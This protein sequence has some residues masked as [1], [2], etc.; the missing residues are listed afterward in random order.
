MSVRRCVIDD[1]D[2]GIEACLFDFRD[3]GGYATGK[4]CRLA[5]RQNANG[6]IYRWGFLW[7]FA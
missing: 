4:K 6:E 2:F 5:V 3:A 7:A 1:D